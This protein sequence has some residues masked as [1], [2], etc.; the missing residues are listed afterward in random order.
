M[1]D[2]LITEAVKLE[3]V[4]K[5]DV[6]V[7]SDTLYIVVETGLHY[8]DPN[9]P[10]KLSKVQTD[11]DNEDL[12]ALRETR[13]RYRNC[14]YWVCS[15]GIKGT[16][17][18]VK[19]VKEEMSIMT[20]DIKDVKVGDVIL[21]PIDFEG[22]KGKFKVLEVGLSDFR[23]PFRLLDL[24]DN[25]ASWGYSSKVTNPVEVV[26][27][28]NHKHVSQVKEGDIIKLSNKHVSHNTYKVGLR[29][30]GECWWTFCLFDTALGYKSY[31]DESV[32]GEY[33]EVVD[34]A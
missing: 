29:G 19:G 10:F 28:N 22:T 17:Q 9:K 31:V 2:N 20:K 7:H 1:Q 5:G 4:K 25:N 27:P 32:V 13:D 23:Q 16:V 11:V 14:S 21:L 24:Q 15:K 12:M 30:D 18:V 3:E 6:I 34:N 26:V 8:G 33:V